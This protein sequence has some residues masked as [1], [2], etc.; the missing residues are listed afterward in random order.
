MKGGVM[1]LR[2]KRGLS[3]V[4]TT[5]IIILLVLVAIGIIWVVVRGVIE[6]SSGQIDINTK[7]VTTN[8]ILAEATCV[9]GGDCVVT[10][11]K[12]GG[13]TLN[14]INIVFSN[15]AGSGTVLQQTGDIIVSRTFPTLNPGTD[16]DP[17]KVKVAGYFNDEDGNPISC[18][19]VSELSVTIN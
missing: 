18:P 17:D 1:M 8:L 12:N 14:G 16:G 2:N 15:S 4:V 5:L 7:C 10:V 11:D 19:Q 3:T 9:T 13:H 6:S